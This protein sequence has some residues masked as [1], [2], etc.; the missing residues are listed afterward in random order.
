MAQIVNASPPSKARA[1]LPLLERLHRVL[2]RFLQSQKHTKKTRNKGLL[3][4]LQLLRQYSMGAGDVPLGMRAQE[5]VFPLCTLNRGVRCLCLQPELVV[6]CGICWPWG[7]LGVC[8]TGRKVFYKIILLYPSVLCWRP[9]RHRLRRKALCRLR[10][11]ERPAST[12]PKIR[13]SFW[14]AD[15]FLCC[16]YVHQGGEGLCLAYWPPK[17]KVPRLPCLYLPALRWFRGREGC[18]IQKPLKAQVV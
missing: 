3:A 4:L 6:A 16:L 15:R 14:R 2:E 18:V 9:A 12:N 13:W 5:P 11:P 17:R 8:L 7:L 10:A 1:K